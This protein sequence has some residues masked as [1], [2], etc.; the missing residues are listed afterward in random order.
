[1]RD[2]S[3][4]NARVP[5][6]FRRD[7]PHA[8]CRP[9]GFGPAW[10][11]RRANSTWAAPKNSAV[12]ASS[13]SFFISGRSITC[14]APSPLL[15]LR[16]SFKNLKPD[17]YLALKT[18]VYDHPQDPNICY[19]MHMQNNDPTNFWA[20]STPVSKKNLELR[21]TFS[22]GVFVKSS[23]METIS[24]MARGFSLERKSGCA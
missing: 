4:K 18:Q 20:L 8:I 2:E 23:K 7:H 9:L 24:L 1:M 3:T 10:R 12:P 15:S 19:F 17:G 6:G 21:G 14:P 16:Q 13:M 11:V 5:P 22:L